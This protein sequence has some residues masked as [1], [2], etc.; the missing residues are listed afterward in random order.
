MTL[1]GHLKGTLKAIAFSAKLCKILLYDQAYFRSVQRGELRD[2]EDNYV[3]W[4]SYPAI[5]ALKNWDLSDKRVF[6]YGSGYSTLFWAARA[7]EVVS[8]DHNRTWHE[9]IARLAPPNAR[10][11]LSPIEKDEADPSAELREQ[12]AKYAGAIEGRF[13]VVVIDGYARSRVRYQCAQAA[14]PHLDE[15]GLIILDNSDWLPA[16]SL[17]LRRAGL[18]EVD[19]SGPVPG[20]NSCQTTSFFLTR[21]FDFR[22]ANGRQPSVPIGGKPYNWEE[23]L[24]RQLIDQA[25]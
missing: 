3:P 22:S 12:F 11:I 19:F 21:G 7:K 6:E 14:L 25:R 8:V 13:Q 17:F 4:F 23:S 9:R 20:S 5:E 16:T 1:L 15:N 10:L 24:E 18:I 2:R